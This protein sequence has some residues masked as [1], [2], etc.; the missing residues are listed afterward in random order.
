MTQ[1]RRTVLLFILA[2]SSL[3]VA[4]PPKGDPEV[5]SVTAVRKVAFDAFDQNLNI[6]VWQLQALHD[7]DDGAHLKDL[8]G[9]W[10]IDGG[11]VL[12]GEENFLIRG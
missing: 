10:F 9:F 5:K 8:V 12:R 11:V 3:A 1:R 7:V 4:P 2:F 6:A